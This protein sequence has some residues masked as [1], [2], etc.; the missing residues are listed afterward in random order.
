MESTI[1]F[2]QVHKINRETNT[3]EE[4]NT[5]NEDLQGYINSL[6]QGVISNRNYKRYK[7]VRETA[8]INKIV[9][10]SVKDEGILEE[11]KHCLAEKYL[12]A[13][14][15]GQ[16]R[17]KNLKNEIRRGYL[18]EAL[19]QEEEK[20]YY[21]ISKVE[22]DEFIDDE[23]LTNRTGLPYKD[24]ILKTALFIYDK[25]K[26]REDIWVL[27][28]ANSEYW[29]KDFLEVE[30]LN[31]DEIT[32][33]KV[34]AVI[35]KAIQTGTIAEKDKDKRSYVDYWN[36]RNAL[37]TYFQSPRRFNYDEMMEYMFN[38][39]VPEHESLV[40]LE[41]IKRIIDTKILIERYDTDFQ[42]APE[43]IKTK[44][45]KVFK[46]NSCI[47]IQILAGSERI[48]EFISSYTE[49]DK[50]Y[51]RIMTE[52]DETYKAFYHKD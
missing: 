36:L 50:R 9:E 33:K 3:V 29:I 45:K 40:D 20:F 19:V 47:D 4:K 1:I 15:V 6:M 2:T 43:V 22:I 44:I 42:I 27:D 34:F 14:I 10:K 11:E 16:D 46:A 18:I 5:S 24:K 35:E 49:D 38:N 37:V 26:V 28:K 7:P 51:I 48:R 8:E 23:L 17:I 25:Q 13:E 31:K 32:T 21:S 41:K 12:A 39:Y 52:N 30:E